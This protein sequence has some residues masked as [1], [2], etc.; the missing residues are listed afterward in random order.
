LKPNQDQENGVTAPAEFG[1]L[2][3]FAGGEHA[4]EIRPENCRHRGGACKPV[5]RRRPGDRQLRG[6]RIALVAEGLRPRVGLL[7]DPRQG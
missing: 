7:L 2:L 1:D 5:D 4:L 6:A 3:A